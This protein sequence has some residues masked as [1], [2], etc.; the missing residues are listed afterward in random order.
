[1]VRENIQQTYAMDLRADIECLARCHAEYDKAIR[2]FMQYRATRDALK[3][4]EG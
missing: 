3:T 1:V 4:I 2:R